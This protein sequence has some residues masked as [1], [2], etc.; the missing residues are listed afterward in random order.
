TLSVHPD[1]ECQYRLIV[2]RQAES[3]KDEVAMLRRC[4]NESLDLQKAI[5]DRCTYNG[6]LHR[7]VTLGEP[8]SQEVLSEWSEAPEI[9]SLMFLDVSQSALDEKVEMACLEREQ[10]GKLLDL[11]KDSWSLFDGRLGHTSLAEHVIDTGYA[12]KAEL[13]FKLTRKETPF[14]WDDSCQASMDYL[15][16]CL[17]SKPIWGL[18]DFTRPFFIHTDA[19][20]LG[21][22]EALMQKDDLGPDVAVA[23]ASRTLHK[24]ER[25][26]STPEKECWE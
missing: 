18:P 21:L 5:I 13:L 23:F 15:K 11:L 22:G 16:N 26:Y 19:C 14:K 10:K 25:P 20:D 24:A 6:Y 4:L 12:Q 8:T 7:T 9:G 1:K 17:I 3:L 2:W